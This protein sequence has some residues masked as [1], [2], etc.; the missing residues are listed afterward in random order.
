MSTSAASVAPHPSPL[1]TRTP[2][3]PAPT[4]SPPPVEERTFSLVVKTGAG[5]LPAQV[6]PLSVKSHQL[7]DPPH[8]TAAE[9]NTAAWIV[10]AAYPT[11]S[12]TG[13]TYVYGH[14]CRDIECPFTHLEQTAPGDSVVVTTAE[15]TLTYVVKRTGLSSKTASS[16]PLWASDSTVSDRLVL[17]SCQIRDDELTPFNVVVEAELSST[18]PGS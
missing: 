10:Q 8:E 14:A 11:V 7:V 15:G 17:V 1:S 13:T 2:A 6:A 9:W 18:R 3:A 4:P 16:L 5:D 12:S